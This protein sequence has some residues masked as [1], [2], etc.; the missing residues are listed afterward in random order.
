MAK[1]VVAVR[2]KR[3]VARKRMV[4]VGDGRTMVGS[5]NLSLRCSGVNVGI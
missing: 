5:G 3:R 1:A 2:A 4:I